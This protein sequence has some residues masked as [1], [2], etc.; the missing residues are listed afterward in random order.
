MQFIEED[1]WDGSIEKTVN[2]KN[3]LSHDEDDE[4]MVEIHPSIVA[5]TQ[6]QQRTPLRRNESASPSTPQGG[7]SSATS[8]ACTPNERGTKFR[9]LNEIYEK[10]AA[11]E[12]MNSLFDLYCHF[13]DPIHFEEAIKYRKWI[14]AMDE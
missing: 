9:N 2:V 12:G 10:E 4:E 6:G 8:S 14:E 5:P 13:D 3:C 7:D 1:A 11:N